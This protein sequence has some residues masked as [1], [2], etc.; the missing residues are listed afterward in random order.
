MAKDKEAKKGDKKGKAA[1][2]EDLIGDTSRRGRNALAGKGSGAGAAK[3]AMGGKGQG[4]QGA[5]A[6][7]GTRKA[8]KGQSTVGER[9]AKARAQKAADRNARGEGKF[10]F[11]ADDPERAKIRKLLEK[12]VKAETSTKDFAAKY[13]VETWKVRLVAKE[14]S[15][16]KPVA[17]R[18]TKS[19]DTGG[20]LMMSPPKG[21]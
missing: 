15:R 3:G 18:L 16:E 21:R 10:F 6:G 17:M 14:M 12:N 9:G 5:A 1:D 2:A 4:R 20:V 8:G 13:D 11:P 19:G 7:V